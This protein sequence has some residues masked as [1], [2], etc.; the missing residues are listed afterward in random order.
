M[1]T[2]PMGRLG[3]H[4]MQIAMAGGL[5]A[6]GLFASPVRAQAVAGQL[7]DAVSRE[8]VA[9]M[10]VR[11]FR[12]DAG[13]RVN[14][15]ST[16]SDAMGQFELVSALPGDYQVEFGEAWPHIS[17][18][19]PDALHAGATVMHRFYIPAQRW[20][21]DKVFRPTGFASLEQMNE[22]PLLLL[23]DRAVHS[24]TVVVM[25]IDENGVPIPETI[26][27]PY[28]TSVPYAAAVADAVRDLRYRPYIAEGKPQR[29]AT[30]L[31][32]HPGVEFGLVPTAPRSAI[33]AGMIGPCTMDGMQRLFR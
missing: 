22:L 6:I 14:V 4:L 29:A 17:I 33:P 32:F 3:R 15:D 21:S 16:K 11:L 26:Y 7:L 28:T 10:T 5:L 19:D 30:C 27:T 1:T 13:L 2:P 23:D 9:N 8:P 24:V 18:T 20:A 25:V 12:T 31:V